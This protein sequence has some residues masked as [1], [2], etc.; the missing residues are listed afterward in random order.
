[1]SN[2]SP[3]DLYEA[4]KSGNSDTLFSKL[5][6]KNF[7]EVELKRALFNSLLAGK[8]K[9]SK[10]LLDSFPK[11]KVYSIF[12]SILR[13]SILTKQFTD[14]DKEIIVERLLDLVDERDIKFDFDNFVGILDRSSTKIN[15][16][17][18]AD[19]FEY[20]LTRYPLKEEQLKALSHIVLNKGKK[21]SSTKS[22]INSFLK[23]N[24]KL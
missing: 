23:Q 13:L 8:K 5:L 21:F 12:I 22:V 19:I 3:D 17:I 4:S 9:M 1:M 2:P 20:F 14:V 11:D 7:D 16:K 6:G 10:L 15:D 24:I 18:R